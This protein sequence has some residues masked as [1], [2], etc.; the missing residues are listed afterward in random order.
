MDA[1]HAMNAV[2]K[3]PQIPLLSDHAKNIFKK[4]QIDPYAAS[5]MFISSNSSSSWSIGI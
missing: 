1:L 3:T 4:M 2:K 5:C